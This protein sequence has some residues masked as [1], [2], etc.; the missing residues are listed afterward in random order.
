[1]GPTYSY[2][3]RNT[4]AT[5]TG[6]GI[7]GDISESYPNRDNAPFTTKEHQLSRASLEPDPRPF[8]PQGVGE[9]S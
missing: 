8:Q 6:T 1:M 7:T 9:G 2:R 3:E 4:Q 5:N